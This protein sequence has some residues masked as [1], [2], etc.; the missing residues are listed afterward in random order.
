MK[1]EAKRLC[2]KL[3]FR[4]TEKISD[5]K[6]GLKLCNIF[7]GGEAEGGLRVTVGTWQREVA[8]SLQ[9]NL[10]RLDVSTVSVFSSL[11]CVLRG[12]QGLTLGQVGVDSFQNVNSARTTR[13]G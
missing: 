2:S 8:Q 5:S 11:C 13:K 4:S 10:N 7:Q 3:K 6:K 1:A 9:R 12:L